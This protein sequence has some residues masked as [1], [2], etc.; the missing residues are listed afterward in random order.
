MKY[1]RLRFPKS[2]TRVL[3]HIADNYRGR[4]DVGLYE[5]AA[6]SAR[7]GEPLEVGYEHDGEVEMIVSGFVTL[8]VPR[9]TV[10]YPT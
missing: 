10:E 7:D 2:A 1:A 9:P 8:G 5:K 3:R 4:V 6:E